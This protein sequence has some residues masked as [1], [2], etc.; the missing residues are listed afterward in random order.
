MKRL[1][2]AGLLL[3]FAALTA[4]SD[5]VAFV[6]VNVVP[7]DSPRVLAAQTV[8]VDAGRVTIVGDV[9]STAVPESASVVDGTDRYLIPGLAEMHADV[10][11]AGSA[12][13]DRTLTLFA[14]NVDAGHAV[15]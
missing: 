1:P 10:P 7:M 9:E 5:P 6:N 8:I 2:G 13:L 14:A 15:D 4:R 12:S 11:P 3:L